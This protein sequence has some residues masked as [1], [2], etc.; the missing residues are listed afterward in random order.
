M[1]QRTNKSAKIAWL[2][3]LVLLVGDG[4]KAISGAVCLI[5]F[6]SLVE[7]IGQIALRRKGRHD[8]LHGAG[9]RVAQLSTRLAGF[10]PLLTRPRF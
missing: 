7:R 4:L 5:G 3:S 10:L 9:K 1:I 2:F 8:V 6:G